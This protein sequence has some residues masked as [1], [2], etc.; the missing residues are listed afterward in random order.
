MKVILQKQTP[1]L[2]N[3]LK[4]KEIK[5]SRE[6]EAKKESDDK[7]ENRHEHENVEKSKVIKRKRRTELERLLDQKKYEISPGE[8][9]AAMEK[10][11]FYAPTKKE[12]MDNLLYTNTVLAFDDTK[13]DYTSQ[14][15]RPELG[16][17]TAAIFSGVTALGDASGLGGAS[18]GGSVRVGGV[19]D[20][21]LL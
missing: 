15:S 6:T 16:A 11:K 3:D 17:M 13:S 21:Y 2:N 19:G 5:N 14:C 7:K 8:R 1:V 9:R 10:H 12:S 20:V 4:V 18:Q